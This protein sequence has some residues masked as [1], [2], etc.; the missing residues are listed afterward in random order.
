[1]KGDGTAH[2]R[3]DPTTASGREPRE[4]ANI[5]WEAVAA[6]LDEV[7]VADFKVKIAIL[8]RTLFPRLLFSI[9]NKRALKE[10]D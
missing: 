1:M 3:M 9:M 4:V 6:G 2:A 7:V 8:L 10:M 5:V